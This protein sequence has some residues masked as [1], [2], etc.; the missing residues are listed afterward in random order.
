MSF[1]KMELASWGEICSW[2]IKFQRPGH[3]TYGQGVEVRT[4]YRLQVQAGERKGTRCRWP[5]TLGRR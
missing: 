4:R 3:H 5:L 2:H 1:T